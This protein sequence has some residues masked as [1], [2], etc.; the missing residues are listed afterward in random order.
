MRQIFAEGRTLVYLAMQNTM[1]NLT[2][3]RIYIKFIVCLLIIFF[4]R[5][6]CFLIIKFSYAFLIS[7]KIILVSDL[8]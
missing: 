5:T 8:G 7:K 1:A 4:P 2:F 3:I 6:S